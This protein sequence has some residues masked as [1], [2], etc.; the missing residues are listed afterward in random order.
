[1]S[2]TPPPPSTDARNRGIVATALTISGI[3]TIAIGIVLGIA[4]DPLLYLVVLVGIADLI[5][6]RMF[7][8]GRIGGARRTADAA[9]LAEADPSYNPYARED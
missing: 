6:A 4:I 7:A 3:A 8:S 9:A 5:F 2:A 1:M